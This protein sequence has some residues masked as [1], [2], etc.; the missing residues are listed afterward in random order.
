MLKEYVNK[1]YS[2]ALTN[3]VLLQR[4]KFAATREIATWEVK[5]LNSWNKV[6]IERITT[7][8]AIATEIIVDLGELAPE[9]VKVEIYYGVK[10]ERYAIEKP[11]IIELKRPQRLEDTKWLYRYKGNALKNLG[12]PCWHYAVRVYPYHDKLPH[13]FLLGLVKWKGFF[14]F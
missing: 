12:N 11:Y 9:D 1:F 10:A 6:N 8:D 13:K 4:D 3:A 5:A 14:D 2:K 7:H